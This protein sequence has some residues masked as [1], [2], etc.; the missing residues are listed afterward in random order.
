MV[1]WTTTA[2]CTIPTAGS[3]SD[4]GVFSIWAINSRGF[5]NVDI[6]S[7]SYGSSPDINNTGGFA[8]LKP[9]ILTTRVV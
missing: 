6:C 9:M 5:V 2:V 8:L 1:T 7:D 4:R 3:P